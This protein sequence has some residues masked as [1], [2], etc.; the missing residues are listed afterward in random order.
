MLDS[1]DRPADGSDRTL[2]M[3]LDVPYRDSLQIQKAHTGARPSGATLHAER[4]DPQQV[5]LEQTG[6]QE[7]GAARMAPVGSD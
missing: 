4:T 2:T 3:V 1:F 5:E 6:E 7:V